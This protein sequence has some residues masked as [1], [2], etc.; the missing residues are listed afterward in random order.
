MTTINSISDKAKIGQNVVFGL[1]VIIENDVEIGNNVEIGH[2]VVIRTNV[3]IGDNC[4][5]LDGAILG[6]MPAAASMSATTG[7]ARDLSPLMLGKAVT[8]GAGCI[9]YRGTE[10]DDRVFFGYLSTIRK[11][12]TIGEGTIIGRGATVENKVSIGK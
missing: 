9:I 10:I 1:G 5:I 6:K 2:N 12:H 4:K 3:I 7:T 8:V 11:R